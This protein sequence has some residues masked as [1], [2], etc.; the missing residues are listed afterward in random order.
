MSRQGMSRMAFERARRHQAQ[1]ADWDRAPPKR[2]GRSADGDPPRRP[3]AATVPPT[4]RNR[5][6]FA[7]PST[8]AVAFAIAVLL[9][10]LALGAAGKPATLLILLSAG[11]FLLILPLSALLLTLLP[12]ALL[13]LILSLTALLLSLLLAALLLCLLL[14]ALL[15][16]IAALLVL[17]VAVL[18]H[19][20]I[21]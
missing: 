17:R 4:R 11:L 21:S 15:L 14:A 3:G 20:P 8:V 1:S 5:R 12:A 9:L 16:L 2:A 13:L 7:Q 10:R 18:V 19:G 6:A